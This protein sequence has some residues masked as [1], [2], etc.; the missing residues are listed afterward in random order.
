MDARGG[1]VPAA[2]EDAIVP[3]VPPGVV[4]AGAGAAGGAGAVRDR[5]GGGS[6]SSSAPSA[7]NGFHQLQQQQVCTDRKLEFQKF[8]CPNYLN[9]FIQLKIK[10]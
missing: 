9:Y 7:I 4:V 2:V 1:A 5:D 8:L 6:L 3:V 10:N